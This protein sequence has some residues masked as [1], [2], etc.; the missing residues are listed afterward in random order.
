MDQP[1]LVYSGLAAPIYVFLD[2]AWNFFR[3]EGMQIERVLCRKDN[4]LGKRALHI[5][6]GRFRCLVLVA[7]GHKKRGPGIPCPRLRLPFSLASRLS[8][9]PS[10]I[11]G[12]APAGF[13]ESGLDHR[14][15]DQLLVGRL[16]FRLDRAQFHL[17]VDRPLDH[18]SG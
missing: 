7:P 2:D 5:P 3:S 1:D 18:L 11:A 16:L 10:F 17:F 15:I 13:A 8:S 6:D 14:D 9:V 4:R 12:Q